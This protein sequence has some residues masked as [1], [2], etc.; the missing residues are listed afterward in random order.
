MTNEEIRELATK[1]IAG[2]GAPTVT[3]RSLI[4]MLAEFGE[5]IRDTCQYSKPARDAHTDKMSSTSLRQELRRLYDAGRIL[6]AIKLLRAERD[7]PLEEAR[8]F[9]AARNIV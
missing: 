2:D 6:D 7:M 4:D 9:A 1:A 8:D 5:Q 3:Q